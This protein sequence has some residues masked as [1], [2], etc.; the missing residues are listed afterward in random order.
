MMY[1]TFIQTITVKLIALHH[2][3]IKWKH[4]WVLDTSII[5]FT[6]HLIATVEQDSII[7]WHLCLQLIAW[8]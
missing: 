7:D 1:A 5:E 2:T 6:G 4:L 3:F 8:H